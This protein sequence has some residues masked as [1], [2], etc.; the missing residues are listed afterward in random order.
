MALEQPSQLFRNLKRNIKHLQSRYLNRHLRTA[1]TGATP[2]T[3]YSLDVSAFAV[4]SH[5]EFEQFFEETALWVL[6][7]AETI[8]LTQQHTCRAL[9][10]LLAYAGDP[11]SFDSGFFD[12]IRLRMKTLKP[13]HSKL[14]ESNNGVGIEYLKKLFRPL[15]LHIPDDARQVA[16]L[17]SLAKIRGDRAHRGLLGARI[18]L[19]A[20]AVNL[21]VTDCLPIASDLVASAQTAVKAFALPYR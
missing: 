4:L 16:A 12:A 2:S 13:N 11:P 18:P 10:A 14:V 20:K 3:P 1:P 8:W 21:S 15:G 9:V 5:A 19:D 7:E 6:D 17:A